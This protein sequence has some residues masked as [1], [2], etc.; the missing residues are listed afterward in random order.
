VFVML[1]KQD[2]HIDVRSMRGKRKSQASVNRMHMSYMY[3]CSRTT[4]RF[5][6]RRKEQGLYRSAPNLMAP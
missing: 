2:K 4:Y 3:P 1:N 5:D 6:D